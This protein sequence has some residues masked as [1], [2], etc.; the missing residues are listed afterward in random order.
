MVWSS[1]KDFFIEE[2]APKA[3]KAA[4]RNDPES[5]VS[6]YSQAVSALEK[7]LEAMC[8]NGEG[9]VSGRVNFLN[10][11]NLKKKLGPKWERVA[12]II[13]LV[14]HD[15]LEKNLGEDDYFTRVNED[16]YVI[17]FADL[18]Q[19]QARLKCI[20]I[21]QAILHKLLGE[22]P[23]TNV[24]EMRTAVT[25]I[26]GKLQLKKISLYESMEQA[27]DAE[28][29][30]ALSAAAVQSGA[31][32]GLSHG[33]GTPDLA[34]LLMDTA[35]MLEPPAGPGDEQGDNKA[36]VAGK[37]SA[38]A[39]GRPGLDSLL[40]LLGG[41][42]GELSLDIPKTAC[43]LEFAQSDAEADGAGEEVPA[44]GLEHGIAGTSTA[45]IKPE[46]SVV[47]RPLWN[48]KNNVISEYQSQL[49]MK[50][51]GSVFEG[52]SLFGQ[53]ADHRILAGADNFVLRKSLTDLCAVLHD[54]VKNV[55]IIPVHYE[56]FSNS[57]TRGGFA[58]LCASIPKPLHKFIVWEVITGHSDF[59]LSRVF[60]IAKFLGKLGRAI[61]LRTEIDYPHFEELAEMGIYAV[62]CDMATEA[63][64]ESEAIKR[65]ESFATRASRCR[66]GA[67][68]NGL[69]STCLVTASVCAGFD[70]VGGTAVAPELSLPKGVKPFTTLD[71]YSGTV[72][73]D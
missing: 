38:P 47:Y 13:H 33:V 50:V 25:Q 42:D 6:E 4:R 21:G 14:T 18:P 15:I 52:E 32:F 39:P 24:L 41:Q 7:H 26:D 72:F 54:N 71:M 22:V 53:N 10:L 60:D 35:L 49:C 59:M 19:D 58:D 37:G 64:S 20:L 11:A 31:A 56:T 34:K 28:Q 27:F 68:I 5:D 46:I 12:K 43:D 45:E 73:D 9:I 40:D 8:H 3:A 17:V 57:R 16:S 70:Y 55:I 36:A 69:R 44:P 61:I 2:S 30:D 23:D 62:G 63:V 51:E 66:L 67:Y 1:V 29:S 65:M 48:I